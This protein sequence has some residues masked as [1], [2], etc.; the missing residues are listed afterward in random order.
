M[1]ARERKGKR[2]G[3]AS[4]CAGTRDA[5]AAALDAPR[6]LAKLLCRILYNVFINS[7]PRH[8][9]ER[10][11][12][13]LDESP[14]VAV[15]PR[16]EQALLCREIIAAVRALPP[17]QSIAVELASAE[18]ISYGEAAQAIGIPVGTFRS[19]LSRGR[20]SLRKRLREEW[21]TEACSF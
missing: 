12:L 19:R 2:R 9:R 16:Q 5:Q 18:K 8:M 4:R 15:P 21:R 1:R 6:Q 7:R 3:S 13:T 14:S 17:E 11:E 20:D 10:A